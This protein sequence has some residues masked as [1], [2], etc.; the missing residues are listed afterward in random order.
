MM[1]SDGVGGMP[2]SFNCTPENVQSLQRVSNPMALQI[3][4]RH[5][6]FFVFSFGYIYL[7]VNVY[8][9]IYIYRYIN[10]YTCIYIY[11]FK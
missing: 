11:I 9:Y 4:A 3:N 5:L 8:I 2:P 1:S 6:A 7:L 10:I